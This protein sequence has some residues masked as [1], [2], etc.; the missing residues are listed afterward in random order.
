MKKYYL[1]NRQLLKVFLIIL[2]VMVVSILIVALR[3]VQVVY[4]TEEQ[5]ETLDLKKH[6][7]LVIKPLLTAN[8]YK[9]GGFYDY[10]NGTCDEK[11]LTVDID[12]NIPYK[13]TSSLKTIVRLEALGADT[14][15]DYELSKDTS[16]LVRYNTIVM[17]HS[18]YVTKNLFY[19]LESHPHVI[20]LYPNALY[21]EVEI[22]DGKMT[23]IRGH[24]YPT[25]D[26]HNGFG[27]KHDNTHPYE[28]DTSCTDLQFYDI[29]NGKMLNCYPENFVLNNTI[30]FKFLKDNSGEKIFAWKN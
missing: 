3:P 26:I 17:L 18:E 2:I 4:F 15:T 29:P 24:G 8:A 14:I 30:I 25:P 27:W 20:Y 28:Y 13:F 10:Y 23:L 21:A 6:S 11:C 16:M 12:T 1:T 7:I 5:L 22:K 19:A 9:K